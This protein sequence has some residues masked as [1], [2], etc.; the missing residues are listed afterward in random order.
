MNVRLAEVNALWQKIIFIPDLNR[1][2]GL[3]LLVYH[4]I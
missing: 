1:G 4:H 3:T 2:N